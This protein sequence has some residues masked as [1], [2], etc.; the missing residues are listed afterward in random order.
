MLRQDDYLKGK[1][2][3]VGWQY[4]SPYGGHLAA[5]MVMGVLANRFRKGWGSWQ[6]IFANIPK[7]A[8]SS[9][10]PAFNA[11]T[12]WEPGFVKLLHEVEGIFDGTQSMSK[13]ALYWCD[14]RYVD[15]PFFQ[16]KILGNPDHP[17]IVEMNTLAL[18]K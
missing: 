9:N 5:C 1:L 7:Y 16:N 6:E 8:A 18:F 13:D 2:V 15:T 17:R 14:T 3:D 10:P 4:G 12:M 11:P